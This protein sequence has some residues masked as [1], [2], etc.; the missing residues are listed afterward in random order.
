MDKETENQKSFMAELAIKHQVLISHTEGQVS[1]LK[2]KY[3]D[4]IIQNYSISY[5][6]AQKEEYLC[7]IGQ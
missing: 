1:K 4:D 5:Y 3:L 7:F 2:I 6:I